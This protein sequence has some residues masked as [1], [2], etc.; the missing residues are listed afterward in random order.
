M[1]DAELRAYI[2]AVTPPDRSCM[3]AAR[4]RQAALAKPPGSLGQ[5]EE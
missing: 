2:E 4:Q 3:E 5:L 1:T